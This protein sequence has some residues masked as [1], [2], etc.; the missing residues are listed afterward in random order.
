MKQN[1]I[2][3]SLAAHKD[4]VRTTVCWE[5]QRTDDQTLA[6]GQ[7]CNREE[8]GGTKTNSQLAQEDRGKVQWKRTVGKARQQTKERRTRSYDRKN[9]KINAMETQ[10]TNRNNEQDDTM[11]RC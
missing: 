9:S 3:R 8:V 2:R 1:M 4:P 11:K 5:Q 10:I 7:R 6:K